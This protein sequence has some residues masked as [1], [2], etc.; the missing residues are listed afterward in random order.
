MKMGTNNPHIIINVFGRACFNISADLVWETATLSPKLNGWLY[1][2]SLVAT[3][4]VIT[5]K[6]NY[7]EPICDNY[8]N[9]IQFTTDIWIYQVLLF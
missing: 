3:S 2:S 4:L 1:Y 6:L 9:F 7:S 5:Q 8:M